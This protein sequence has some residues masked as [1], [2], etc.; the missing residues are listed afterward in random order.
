M[1]LNRIRRIV[2]W[3]LALALVTGLVMQSVRAA[4]MDVKMMVS[5]ASD[6]AMPGKCDGC[7]SGGDKMSGIA[8]AVPCGSLVAMSV[9]DMLLPRVLV[10]AS[11]WT[12]TPAVA[13][14]TPPLDPSPPRPSVLS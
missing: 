2:V 1:S 7:G 12:V 13:G 14:W 4:D 3:G 6:M 10:V 9:T 8:C 5:A 11:H